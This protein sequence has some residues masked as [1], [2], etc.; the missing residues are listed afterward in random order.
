[1]VDFTLGPLSAP[2]G[3]QLPDLEPIDA[4]RLQSAIDATFLLSAGGYIA[5]TQTNKIL[6]KLAKKITKRLLERAV[7]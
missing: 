1:M 6:E 2:I 4:Y 7:K 5:R 3:E